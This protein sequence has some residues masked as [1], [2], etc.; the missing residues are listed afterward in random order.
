MEIGVLKGNGIGPKIV[1]ATME[2]VDACGLDIEW[3][4]IP[5]AVEA[6]EKYG[7]PVPGESIQTMKDLKVS[8]KGPITVPSLP[9]F[10][11]R[12]DAG[13]SP[14]IVLGCIADDFT[15][16]A[17]ATSYLAKGGLHTCLLSGVPETMPDLSDAEA[18]V[19]ALKTRTQ[20]T[21]SAVAETLKALDFLKSMDAEHIYLKY[22]STFDSTPHG[23]IGPICD[24]VMEALHT[25]FTLLCP[26]LP[27]NGRTVKD[28]VLYVNGVPLHESPMKDHPL[29]PMWDSRISELMAPQSKYPCHILPADGEAD[30]TGYFI[31]DYVTREDGAAIAQRYRHLP[32]LTGGSGLLEHLAAVYSTCKAE[33][34]RSDST[35]GPALILAGSCSTATRE[36]IRIYQASGAY[37]LRLDPMAL[38]RGECTPKSIWDSLPWK[39]F[40][41]I[42]LYSSDTPE[43]VREAQSV[44]ADVIS[45]VLEETMAELARLAVKGGVTRIIVAGGETSGAVTRG[46][47][48]RSFRIGGSVA[49]GV[50]VLTPL[51]CPNLRL[52]LKSGNFGQP[53]FFERA[54]AS[55]GDRQEEQALDQQLQQAVWVAHTLFQLGKTSGSTGNLSFRRGDTL[56][57]SRSGTCF[58]TLTEEDFSAVSMDG[59][60]LRGRKSSRELPLHRM[61]YLHNPELS[62]VVHTHGRYGVLWSCVPGLDKDDCIP[63]ITP[64]LAM[65]LGK[66]RLI[67]YAKPGSAELFQAL[68]E[69]LDGNGYLLARHGAL[70]GGK[71]LMDAFY[72]VEELE[73]SACIAW[74]L[75]AAEIS[76]L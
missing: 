76:P 8:L 59:E 33:T 5:I 2:V 74:Q 21:S 23:N 35:A 49:P 63:G 70:V 53:D 64:Y 39:G 68:E 19:I 7:H 30:G 31:P 69:R 16:A 27:D 13:G 54:L 75:R 1:A 9:G 24:A 38:Y 67:P 71:E 14:M 34:C 28:G 45:S 4:N 57:I 43:A 56:Y 51:D 11:Q 50:P 32:L 65:K 72:G 37:S 15:G 73:E 12:A 40:H 17:D 10:G 46:L 66:I 29:T 41:S 22:C 47:G 48:F 25:P 58:G 36:Q 42:L 26:S 18:V 20:E 6:I 61:L 44:G 3:V 52:V 60:L 62:A 55:T